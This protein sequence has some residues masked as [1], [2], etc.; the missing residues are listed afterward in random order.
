MKIAICDDEKEIRE[1]LSNKVRAI[2]PEAEIRMFE[3]GEDMLGFEKKS[4]IYFLDIQMPGRDGIEIAKQLRG[5][6]QDVLLIFVTAAEE[7]VFQ[8]FDV[9][10]FHYL[11]KPFSDEKFAEVLQRAINHVEGQKNKKVPD[12]TAQPRTVL[13]RTGGRYT[14]VCV[15]DIVYAEVL[16]RK[17]TLHMKQTQL[18]YYGKLSDLEKTLGAAFYRVHRAYLIHMKYVVSYDANEVR[19]PIGTCPMARSKYS[20]FVKAFLRFMIKEE[21]M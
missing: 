8:A 11:V 5:K 4:D 13:I 12:A 19:T 21:G 16:N 1:L 20:E 7:Y 2:C 14:K 10:A 18:E 3:S 15:D 17:V 6:Q 9:E